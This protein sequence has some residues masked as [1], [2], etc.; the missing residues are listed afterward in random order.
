MAA[1]NSYCS[2]AE[3]RARLQFATTDT[4][5]D[6]VLES[7]M[8]AVSRLIDKHCG[9]RFWANSTDETRYYTSEFTDVFYCPDDITS[10]TTLATDDDGDRVYETTWVAADF[11]LEP[12]NAVLDGEPYTKIRVNEGTGNY[13]FP[14]LAKSVKLVGKFGYGTT[15]PGPVKE[16]CLL[17]CERIFKR[18]DAPFGVLGAGGMGQATVIPT[19]DP[20]VQL[21]LSQYVRY[22]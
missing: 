13:A 1:T 17:Q 10:L 19:L 8:T 9:R 7:V 2:L 6:A 18:K 11:D 15:A 4:A 14:T 20:D 12:F 5:D 3:L 16:A 21:M 22:M